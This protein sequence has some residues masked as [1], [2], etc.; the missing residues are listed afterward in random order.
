MKNN[1]IIWGLVIL[2]VL[3]TIAISFGNSIG[4]SQ[5]ETPKEQNKNPF[6][7]FSKYPTADYNAPEITNTAE[8]QERIIKNRR[9]DKK[10]SVITSPAPDDIAAIS[11]DAE[12]EPAAIP[13][14]ESKLIIIG[15][16]LS[17]KAFLSNEKKGIYSEYSVRIQDILKEDKQKKWQLDETITMDRAGGVVCYPNGQKM[18]YRN[19]WQN[20]PEVNGRYVI[21]LAN[22]DEQNS[23]YS[24]LTAYRLQ[25][26]K[27]TALD[28]SPEFREFDGKNETDFIKLIL[29]KK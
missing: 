8:R 4:Y 11:S 15:E 29:S 27:I 2:V 21:F 18:L 12:S 22:D 5:K 7:D 25:D 23:N 17:S 20:F 24:L 28:K 9:Y 10:L 19:D 1:R 6:G 26:G 13:F 14:A 16:I 3:V